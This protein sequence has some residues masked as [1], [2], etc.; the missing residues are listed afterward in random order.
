MDVI[1]D[2]RDMLLMVSGTSEELEQYEDLIGKA[3]AY[4][5]D[6]FGGLTAI[7]LIDSHE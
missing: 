3:D 7:W 5:I 4:G 2:I 6:I 1:H